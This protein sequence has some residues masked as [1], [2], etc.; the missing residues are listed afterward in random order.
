MR[1]TL[2]RVLGAAFVALVFTAPPAGAV[3]VPNH[4]L[5]GAIT[6]ERIAEFEQFKGACGVA[7]DSKGDV[8]VADYYQN[9]VVVFNKK[10]EY[11]TQI[12]AINPIEAGGA[13]PID[14][15]CDLVV[16]STGQLYVNDYH[17]DVLRFTPSEYPPIHT[18]EKTTTY[19]PP[20][21]IDANNPTGVAVD[22]ASDRI[23]VNDRTHVAVYQPS[24]AP[25]MEGGEEL[26]IGEGSLGDAYGVAI[27]GFEGDAQHPATR[28][29]VYVAD[30]ASGTVKIYDPVLDPDQP[31]MEIRGEGTQQGRFHLSD[32]DLAVDPAD[33]H[34]YVSDN[35]E[36]HFEEK[37]ELVVDEFSPA[38]F[39]RG[40]VPDSFTNGVKSFLQAG[41]PTGLAITGDGELYVTSGNYENAAVFAFGPPA[42]VE[43]QILTVAKA[44]NGEGTVTSIPAAISCGP[45]CEG[46]LDLESIVV[47]K[48]TPA[49]GSVFVGWSGCDEE[50]SPGRCAVEM[51]S[52]R[53]V[54]AEFAA[55]PSA[56][57]APLGAAF[58][59]SALQTAQAPP[60]RT[61]RSRE[62][63]TITQKGNLRVALS[64][65]L[66]P[67]ALPRSGDAPVAVSL[68]GD[69]STTDGSELPQLRTLRIEFNRG[70]RLEYRGLPVCPLEQIRIASSDRA[71]NACRAALVGSGS[72]EANIVLRGQDPYPTTGRLLI[73]NGRAGKKPVLYG[74]IYASKPFATSFVISFAIAHR[75]HGKFGTVLTASLPEA[76]GDWGYVTAIEMR[77]F[78]RYRAG[79]E[80]RSYLSAG[81]PAPKG[82]PGAI[83]TLAR[84]S[85]SFAGGKT[86]SSSLSRD[87]RVR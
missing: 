1:V 50:P 22:P 76:L 35:L 33:G 27:S 51:G 60:I 5:V 37:P 55:A 77:L 49:P 21:V 34:L 40:S 4:P 12:T 66:A 53:S 15:P 70:G 62:G 57:T 16:D 46:E 72:F 67:N 44:G 71:L 58:H 75:A 8:Y 81:C 65:R 20:T 17:R 9:R 31:Q 54:T 48:A 63:Q 47:L 68:G 32:A 45:V 25:V 24:G 11:L 73:F 3:E 43:T 78:R 36:P 18:E 6:G 41:E 85:F 84:A 39:Y 83:F 80:Q 82:F 56:A 7:V 69:I 79:G 38:G 52:G 30:A 19:A 86:L 13:A 42:P 26:R 74:H 87:C 29:D 23:Y 14:G 2:C 10:W 64:G 59:A 61:L 28:G